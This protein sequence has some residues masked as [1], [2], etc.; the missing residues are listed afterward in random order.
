MEPAEARLQCQTRDLN[1]AD[2]KPGLSFMCH[3][4]RTAAGGQSTAAAAT[5]KSRQVNQVKG[6]V[7][8]NAILS[9]LLVGGIVLAFAARVSIGQDLA[10]DALVKSVTNEVIAVIRK[11]NDTL[12]PAKISRLVEATVVPHFDFARMTRL[13]MGRNWRLASPEQQ[14]ALIAEFK[15]LLVH[16]YSASLTLYRD[17]KIEFDALR[18]A[19]GDTD[20]TVRSLVR[21]SGAQPIRIDYEMGKE[22]SGWKVYN[23][24]ID[25]ISLVV[26]YRNTFANQVREH[27]VD[28]LI[29][30]L[31]DKNRSNDMLTKQDDA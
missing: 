28:G 27:G 8:R 23:V 17:Q 15:T 25:G 10:P 11:N 13:A 18:A 21:Q 6:R 7:M 4:A 29:K 26:T 24:S 9:I 16:T 5:F 22:P 14:Q 3:L 31:A 20:V 2:V 30:T 1:N 12:V 19:P